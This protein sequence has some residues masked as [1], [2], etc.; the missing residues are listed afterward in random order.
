MPYT[1]QREFAVLFQKQP[2]QDVLGVCG[3]S[4]VLPAV[5]NR[6]S[7]E[8]PV[9]LLRRL[10]D[11]FR[12][13]F[14][15]PQILLIGRTDRSDQ[16]IVRQFIPKC[17]CSVLC[18]NQMLVLQFVDSHIRDVTLFP[19]SFV[20]KSSRSHGRDKVVVAPVPQLNLLDIRPICGDANC[21]VI[22]LRQCLVDI[23]DVLQML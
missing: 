14:E 7:T 21:T 13:V 11:L 8:R 5:R 23:P 1:H 10:S 20:N 9:N 12:L 18:T 6:R 19:L 15:L 22:E 17:T 3:L 16:S 2:P 4:P